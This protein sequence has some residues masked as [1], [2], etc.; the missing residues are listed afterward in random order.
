MDGVRFV[1]D[2]ETSTWI[3]YIESISVEFKE[4]VRSKLSS[5]CHGSANGESNK[6]IYSYKY[7]IKEFHKRYV[8]KSLDIKKGMI[9]ELL[10]HILVL[11]SLSEMKTVS[12]FFNMEESSIKKGFDIIMYDIRSNK[13]WITEIKSGF[14]G[15]ETTNRKNVRLLANARD[16][17]FERLNNNNQTLWHNAICGTLVALEHTN[18]I[19]ESIIRILETYMEET[20]NNQSQSQTKSVVL[21]SVI[22]NKLDDRILMKYLTAF[23]TNLIGRNLFNDSIIFSIQKGTLY[24]FESFLEEEATNACN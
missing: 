20:Q 8:S 19:K 18:V 24:K 16:D 15:D 10:S 7:T 2:T 14:C 23:K 11:E 13:A 1:H 5:I 21:V 9:A 17:L 22:Y 3:F 12:P 6:S 4:L